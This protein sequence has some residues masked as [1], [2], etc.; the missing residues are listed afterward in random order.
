MVFL[1]TNGSPD[2]SRPGCFGGVGVGRAENP[3]CHQKR[4]HQHHKPGGGGLETHLLQK[5]TMSQNPFL[6]ISIK[7]ISLHFFI[8]NFESGKNEGSPQVRKYPLF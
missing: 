1:V 4:L 7:K 5:I 2:P 8:S 6:A 3:P